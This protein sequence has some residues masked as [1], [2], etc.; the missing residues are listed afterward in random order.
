MSICPSCGSANRP[1]ARFCWNCAGP[2]PSATPPLRPTQDDDRW[3]AEALMDNEISHSMPQAAAFGQ[4]APLL[5]FND[6]EEIMDQSE[7]AMPQLIGGRYE[8]IGEEADTIQVRDHEPWQ[9]CWA[10]DSTANE[11]GEA[12]CMDCGAALKPRVYQ[13]AF[14]ANDKPAGLA[15]IDVV[16]NE[17]AQALLPILW[18]QVAD[19]ERT[20]IV[21]HDSGRGSAETPL[22][23]L[24]ALRVGQALALLLQALH[25]QNLALGALAPADIELMAPGQPRLRNVPHLHRFEEDECADAEADDL[26]A[27]ANLLEALT[28]TPRT[29][30]RLNDDDAAI[31]AFEVQD[32]A[33]VLRDIRTSAIA[34]PAALAERLDALIAER[35]HPFYLHQQCGGVTDTG[36]V[37][38]HNEDSLLFLNLTMDNT[39]TQRIWGAYIVADGMG[40]HAAG[41]IASGLAV[42]GAAEVLLSEYL[43]PTLDLDSSYDEQQAR[44][45]V[46]RAAL[47]ANEYVLNESLARNNDMG[48][49]LTMA[50]IVGDRLTIANVGDSRAYLYRDG[51]MRRITKD[52]SLVMRLVDLGQI[53]EED[54][55]SHP[56]RNAVLRSLGDKPDLEVD[57]FSERLQDGDAILL[58]SDGLW[59]MTRDPEIARI[60]AKH[61]DP[62]HTCTELIQAANQAGGEDN[63]TAL[64]VR[65]SAL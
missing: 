48:S 64:L 25:T 42:R 40:G 44:D 37:R 24:S 3:L 61:A 14:S 22:D 23:E 33:T 49:T 13:G 21:L 6:Q 8:V 36:I 32:L 18:D 7:A 55:Y 2:L 34:K 10:C 51:T 1:G 38:D 50:L 39:S 26:Q 56:Q 62:Q 19:D 41:E 63:I 65:L 28:E 35:M 58:C 16:E 4:T 15:L 17:E 59:E 20:L 9:R 46:K 31:A 60:L 29:T 27:L 12:F 47:Q 45:I 43:A 52:H 57:L 5:P 54:I 30:R 53:T 11:P